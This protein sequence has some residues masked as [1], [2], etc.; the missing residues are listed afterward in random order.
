MFHSFLCIREL[1]ASPGGFAVQEQPILAL[2]FMDS[3]HQTCNAA[4]WKVL[5]EGISHAI[6]WKLWTSHHRSKPHITIKPC[7]NFIKTRECSVSKNTVIIP[8][9]E[10]LKPDI[11]RNTA[12][13][14]ICCFLP[15]SKLFLFLYNI[16]RKIC[17]KFSQYMAARDDCKRGL[18]TENLMSCVEI[19]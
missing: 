5:C 10:S 13:S 16:E 17:Y 11:C 7:S 8:E 3:Q 6:K 9:L 12:F 19:T 14:K 18:S 4:Q 2:Q 15:E 1:Q